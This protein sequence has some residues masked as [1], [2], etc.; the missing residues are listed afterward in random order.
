MTWKFVRYKSLLDGVLSLTGSHPV[1]ALKPG[2]WWVG[3]ISEINMVEEKKGRSRT[4]RP[5]SGVT[6]RSDVGKGS[7]PS[8]IDERVDEPERGLAVGEAEII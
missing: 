3:R 2:Y 6:S 7:C 1:L 4:V 5:T 8:R